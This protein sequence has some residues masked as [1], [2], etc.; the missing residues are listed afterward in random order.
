MRYKIDKNFLF[1]IHR[2]DFASPVSLVQRMSFGK[3]TVTIGRFTARWS[4]LFGLCKVY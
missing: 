3:K 4:D 2:I 1:W